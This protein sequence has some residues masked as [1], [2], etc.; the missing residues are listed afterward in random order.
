MI[1][2]EKKAHAYRNLE[3]LIDTLLSEVLKIIF[4]F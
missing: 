1:A 3:K 4:H 2:K